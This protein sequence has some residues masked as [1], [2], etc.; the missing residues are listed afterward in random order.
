MKKIACLG[1]IMAACAVSA[2]DVPDTYRQVEFIQSTGTQWINTGV[3]PTC[4]D[5]ITAKVNFTYVASG[6]QCVWC[7]R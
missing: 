7:T 5:T 1:A 3:T 2:A 4:T 6:N